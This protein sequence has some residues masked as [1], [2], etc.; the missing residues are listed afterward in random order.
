VEEQEVQSKG[1]AARRGPKQPSTRQPVRNASEHSS[2]RQA[3]EPA[4]QERNQVR[5][6]RNGR[7]SQSTGKGSR[8]SLSGGRWWNGGRSDE[9]LTR[10]SH[11]ENRTGVHSARR[12]NRVDEEPGRVEVRASIIATK[13]GNARGVKGRRKI[14]RIKPA[15]RKLPPTVIRLYG[16]GSEQGGELCPGKGTTE[17][18]LLADFESMLAGCHKAQSDTSGKQ[19]QCRRDRNPL[20]RVSESLGMSSLTDRPYQLESRMRENRP[21]GSEGGA[22]YRNI[23]FLPLSIMQSLRDARGHHPITPRGRIRGRERRSC[24]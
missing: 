12:A 4:S 14:D 20:V 11:V 21:S 16:E 6:K 3:G 7:F 5:E 18:Y 15:R 23:S 19:P 17:E 13:R 10:E 24:A 2:A 9:R 8:S 22:R 1:V